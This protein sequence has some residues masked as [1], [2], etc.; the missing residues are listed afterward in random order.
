[1]NDEAGA[2]GGC[3]TYRVLRDKWDFAQEGRV[4]LFDN[5]TTRITKDFFRVSASSC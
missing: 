4:A 1:M 2:V 5:M 3:P